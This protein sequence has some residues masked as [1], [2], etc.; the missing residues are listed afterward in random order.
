MGIEIQFLDYSKIQISSEEAP[1]VLK[2]LKDQIRARKDWTDRSEHW[3]GYELIEGIPPE[4]DSRAY[5]FNKEIAILKSRM[6]R[7]EREALN[8]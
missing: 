3:E 8:G 6:T 7:K 5:S 1:L 2:D 4:L